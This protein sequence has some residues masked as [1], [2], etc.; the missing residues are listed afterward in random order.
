M[1]RIVLLIALKYIKTGGKTV[2]FYCPY[3][4]EL[5]RL[6]LLIASAAA[7]PGI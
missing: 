4:F 2:E 6:C 1:S 3:L 5:L 7:A